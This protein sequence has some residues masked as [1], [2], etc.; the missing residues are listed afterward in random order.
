MRR[1]RPQRI[2]LSAGAAIALATVPAAQAAAPAARIV[3]PHAATV[4][5]TGSGA[6]TVPRTR[7]ICTRRGRRCQVKAVLR[8]A[9]GSVTLARKD[10]SLAAGKTA[11]LRFELSASRLAVVQKAGSVD[12]TLTITASKRGSVQARLAVRLRLA[13][14][15]STP[16][17]DVVPAPLPSIAPTPTPTPS[18]SAPTPTETPSPTPTAT[19]ATLHVDPTGRYLIDPNGKP[20]LMIGESPQALIGDL[21]EP[22]AEQF[23]ATRSAQGFNTAWINLLC[24]SYTGC[25]QD[26]ATWDGIPPFTTPGDVST[27]NEVYFSHVDRI[28]RLAAKYG[29]VV[30]LDP[31]ET[32]GWLQTLVDNGVGK[33]RAYGE[34]LGRRYAGFSNIV[35]MNGN[36]YQTWGPD[37]DAYVTA[38]AQGIRDTDPTALQTVELNYMSSGSLDDPAWESRIDLNASYTYDPTYVQVLKDYNRDNFLPTLM[39]E[40]SYEG[41]HNPGTTE[42]TPQQLRRQ[43]Y[44][45]LLSGATGQIYGNHYTWQF[46]CPNRDQD[47]NCVGGYKDQLD[48][49]GATQMGYLVRLFSSRPWYELVPDQAHKVVTAGY[50]TFGNDDYVAAAATPDGRLAMAYL[51]SSRTVT[52]DLGTLSGPVVARWYD[53][54]N[55]T[56]TSIGSPLANNGSVSFMLPGANA[57]GADDWVLVLEAS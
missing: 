30:L 41:E 2:A 44:W 34:Y 7:V 33:D 47:G 15:P 29:F 16:T 1:I 46:I 6:F 27:P 38:V 45:S 23:L 49:P 42:G 43:E 37:N 56:F 36:D 52:V 14:R 28:L 19:P 10:L 12:T 20:L 21:T 50:G 13:A 35:W 55:G 48:S 31:A 32:G 26:G 8:R 39:V 54:A 40:A 22:D 18:P 24:D 4:H 3:A 9:S 5:V 25:R 17:D 51:P 53:P 11:T 57:D